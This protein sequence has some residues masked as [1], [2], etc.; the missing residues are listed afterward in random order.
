MGQEVERAPRERGRPRPHGALASPLAS[1]P[2]HAFTLVEILVVLGIFLVLM[3]IAVAAI[4]RA[5]RLNRMIAAEQSV[6]DAIRQGRHSARTGGQPVVLQLKK[7][8]RA[9]SGLVRQVLWQGLEDWPTVADGNGGTGPSPGRTGTGL[10]VPDAYHEDGDSTKPLDLAAAAASR[11]WLPTIP[12]QPLLRGDRLWRGSSSQ[13]PGL[14]LSIAV[15]PP[16]AGDSGVPS[17]LPLVLVGP[18]VEPGQSG[19]A[20][21]DT[22]LLGLVL[23][24]SNVNATSGPTTTQATVA[25]S[26]EILGWFGAGAAVEVSSIADP[27]PDLSG[28]TGHRRN[29]PITAGVNA[30]SGDAESGPLIGGRWTEISLLIDG[31]RVQLYRDG[32]RVGEKGGAAAVALAEPDAERV[33]LGLATIDTSLRL[34]DGCQF[35]D[36]RLERLGDAMAGTLPSGVKPDQDRRITCHPDGR[37]EVDASGAAAATDATIRLTSDSGESAELVITTAGVVSSLTQVAP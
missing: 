15:R 4:V 14:L 33:Y 29:V 32:R 16:V 11:L 13:R 5:P 9:I 3:S 20:A 23:V 24:Q 21:Y 22:A 36:V 2:R 6:A 8:Q 19:F 27:P 34:A 35:D 28:T 10:L 17:I 26:W 30:V 37:V 25:A 18:E 12:G 7:D 1:A 31:D